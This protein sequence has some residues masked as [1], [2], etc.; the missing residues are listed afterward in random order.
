L[1]HSKLAKRLWILLFLTIAAFYFYGLGAYPFV[2]PDEPRYAEVAREMLVHR[3]FITPTL[4]S[5]PWFEKPPMLDWLMAAS[6]RVFGV[7]EYAARLGP[8]LCGLLTAAFVWW[9][10]RA[11]DQTEFN[12]S[13]ADE[14]G[15]ANSCKL[16][17]WST[18]VFLSSLGAIIFSRAASFDI[19]LTMTL[20]GAFAAFFVAHIRHNATS[21]AR[22]I[23]RQRRLLFMFYFFIGLSLLAKGLVGLVIPIGVLALFFILRREWPDKLSLK[24]L[25]WGI[26]IVLLVA[27]AWY[28]PMIHRHGWRFVDQFIV[29]HHFARFLTNKY[30]HPQPLYYYL[31]TLV[32]MILPWTI[33]LGA[34]L[35]S[36]FRSSWGDPE[37]LNR[38]R[39]FALSWI[40][41]PLLFF[42][43][44]G[45]K[46]PGY[47][48]PILPAAAIVVG[49]RLA[50]FR[51]VAG[52]KSL[53]RIS[54]IVVIVSAAAGSWYAVRT[55]DV[56]RLSAS[57]PG[58]VLA[59]AAVWALCFPQLRTTI[60]LFAL[61]SFFVA[62]IAIHS[63]NAITS[64]QCVRDLIAT[65]N[66]NG[67]SST[68]VFLM[69]SDDRTAEFYAGGRL[70]YQ[71][72][73]EPIRFDGARELGDA[74][75]QRGGVALVIIETR[76]E[77]QLTDYT[78]VQAER[79][80]SNGTSTVFAVQVH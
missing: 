53:V 63:T 72:D 57:I 39:M 16:A 55:L 12:V 24:S 30:H 48:L 79:I 25:S 42:S 11:V 28:G 52:R 66:E 10:A 44:S 31:P 40:A 1:E 19:V 41:V 8:A 36:T 21:E 35:F 33:F 73:G 37:P 61:S 7:N 51:R 60:W 17:N 38:L 50:C 13:P 15:R 14:I 77:K 3:D 64:R 70:A 27:G 78:V 46:L 65:A 56:S 9:M 71:P 22:Q 2:G 75:R 68:P 59:A 47:I 69:L 26:P 29:Q 74:I 5:L 54:A 67:Y 80:G 45:S 6:Y 20:T 62:G 58:L 76:W 4:G 34:G 32:W 49:E 18:L 43:F 23:G